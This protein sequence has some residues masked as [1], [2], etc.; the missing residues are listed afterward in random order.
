MSLEG[1]PALRVRADD[2]LYQQQRAAEA[3]FWRTVHPG[4]ME[5]FGSRQAVGPDGRYITE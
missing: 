2:P 4:G 3:E 5:A 1:A